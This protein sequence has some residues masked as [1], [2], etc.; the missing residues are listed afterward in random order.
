MLVGAIEPA[1][2]G[3][4]LK[5]VRMLR[6]WC[7]VGSLGERRLPAM[8]KLGARIGFPPETAIAVASL[9][10]LTE[11]CLG[12]P[13]RAACCSS[14]SLSG[15]ERAILA[16]LAAPVASRPHQAFP[17]IPHGL[18]GALSWAVASVRRLLGDIETQAD[19][20]ARRCPFAT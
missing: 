7:A 8:V 19:I 14:V 5:I 18:P 9:F 12:R 16:L 1:M 15:D 4:A 2:P 11:A 10:E 17:P 3:P 13:L 6:R 20:P